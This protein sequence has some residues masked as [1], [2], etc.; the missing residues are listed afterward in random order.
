MVFYLLLLYYWHSQ[1]ISWKFPWQTPF[2]H[3]K[4][5]VCNIFNSDSFLELHR[6]TLRSICKFFRTLYP[7]VDKPWYQCPLCLKFCST[8]WRRLQFLFFLDEF[9]G[10]S[11]LRSK[12]LWVHNSRVS[13]ILTFFTFKKKPLIILRNCCYLWHLDYDICL[14]IYLNPTKF[15]YN[16]LISLF[17]F[18]YYF[19][20]HWF[21]IYSWFWTQNDPL[22][23]HLKH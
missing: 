10:S 19:L 23:Q 21:G 11:K 22:S 8:M 18:C 14:Y 17:E 1:Q 15:S 16:Q 6:G 7:M 5:F 4:Y 12:S 13:E 9:S 2:S 3:G 20:A